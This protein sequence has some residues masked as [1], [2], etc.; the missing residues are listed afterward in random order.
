MLYRLWSLWAG[1]GCIDFPEFLD[2]MTRDMHDPDTENELMEA[3]KVFDKDGNGFITAVQLRYAMEN[4]GDRVTAE[5]VDE[6]IREAAIDSD[7]RI[8]YGGIYI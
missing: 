1:D 3:F 2:V 4:I 5:E 7:G 6:L 8:D